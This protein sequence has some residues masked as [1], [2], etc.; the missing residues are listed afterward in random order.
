MQID[1]FTFSA[2][3]VNFLILVWL[4]KRFLYQPVLRIIRQREEAIAARLAEADNQAAAAAEKKRAY[5]ELL[6]ETSVVATGEMQRAREEADIFRQELIETARREVAQKRERWLTAVESEKNGFVR[7]ASRRMSACFQQLAERA[8]RD[9][10]DVDLE[11]R[12]VTI[13][14]GKLVH[15]RED[16]H[17][18][19]RN[20]LARTATP[21]IIT[22]AFPLA[23][24][25]Q[26]AIRERIT[27]LWGESTA[28][29]F[30]VDADLLSGIRIETADKRIGWDLRSYLREFEKNLAASLE[31]EGST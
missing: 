15:M 1:W 30:R 27:T 21:L 28:A 24:E 7:E 18:A 4:L 11:Q 29:E 25:H 22:S 17:A 20:E 6:R 26:Q 9:L 14:L 5:E 12:M 19:I 16:E 10:A 23:D 8:L 2:Q 3:I 31:Q 13:L